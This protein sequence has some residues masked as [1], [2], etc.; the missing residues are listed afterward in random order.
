VGGPEYDGITGAVQRW[1]AYGLGMD[2]VLNKMEVAADTRASLLPDIQ[3]LVIGA[4]DGGGTLARI[5]V[6][7]RPEHG[8][9]DHARC[10]IVDHDLNGRCSVDRHHV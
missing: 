8:V 2:D 6:T 7:S 10:S 1:Y 5:P 9:I 3:G 4:L